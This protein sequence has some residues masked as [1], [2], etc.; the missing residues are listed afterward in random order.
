MDM[1]A[2]CIRSLAALIHKGLR[3]VAEDA[4]HAWLAG[5]H[6]SMPASVPASCYLTRLVARADR[7]AMT[8]P[9]IG[10]PGDGD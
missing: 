1:P 2:I 3:D 7:V 10:H 8:S 6:Y 5:R 9:C 4:R